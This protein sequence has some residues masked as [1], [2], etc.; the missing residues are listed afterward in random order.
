MNRTILWIEFFG[1]AVCGWSA[2]GESALDVTPQLNSRPTGMAGGCQVLHYEGATD[3][4]ATIISTDRQGNVYKFGT[5]ASQRDFDPGPGT[6]IRR[7]YGNSGNPDMFVSKFAGDGSYLWTYTIRGTGAETSTNVSVDA[8]GGVVVYGVFSGSAE[9]NTRS[10]EFR[11]AGTFGSTFLLHLNSA[12]GSFRW[13]HLRVGTYEPGLL[14]T[15][16]GQTISVGS[17]SGTRDFD[18]GPEVDYQSSAG[19]SDLY[20]RRIANEGQYV[21]TT[22]I[23][24]PDANPKTSVRGGGGGR[25]ARAAVRG[26]GAATLGRLRKPRLLVV[27]SHLVAR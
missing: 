3:F 15:K 25:L 14:V 5:Y 24:G 20:I 4:D 16:A 13:V 6:D 12:D 26:V 23:G 2:A 21:S 22:V 11:Y 27:H 8:A 19:T 1:V 18:P 9:F 7:P 17:L 10:G